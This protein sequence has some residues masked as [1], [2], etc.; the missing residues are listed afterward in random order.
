VLQKCNGALGLRRQPTPTM[1][2]I[3]HINSVKI[4]SKIKVRNSVFTITGTSKHGFTAEQEYNG[5]IHEV[6]FPL[7]SFDNP[8]LIAMQPA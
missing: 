8:H 1:N 4:G 5:K 2:Q 7:S 6:T 3:K